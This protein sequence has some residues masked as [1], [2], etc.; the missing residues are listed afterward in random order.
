MSTASRSASREWEARTSLDPGPVRQQLVRL[1]EGLDAHMPLEEAVRDFPTAAMNQRPPQVRY[2]PWHLL[3][4]IRLT[5]A[6]ILDYLTD[7]AYVA[8]PWPGA[9]WPEAS[10]SA[11]RAGWDASIAGYL[12]DRARLREM[13]EDTER[14]LLAEIPG[15][16][17]HTLLREIRIVAD[18]TAYHVGEFAIL[19]QVTGTWPRLRAK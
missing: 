17:G 15:T 1:L 11:T 3:E 9:Y 14:D 12:A 4:H 6:D 8:P 16:P 2:T 7:P 10:A 19:R 18:H 13:V 5:Q